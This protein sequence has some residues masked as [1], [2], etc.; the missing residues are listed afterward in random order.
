MT[1]KR[2]KIAVAMGDG[3]GPEIMDATLRILK[4]AGARLD[5]EEVTVGEKAYLAGETK[6]ISDADFAKLEAVDAFL[7]APLNTPQGKGYSSV[8]VAI[9]KHFDLFTNIRPSVSLEPVINSRSGAQGVDLVMIRENLEDLYAGIESRPSA[10]VTVGRKVITKSESERIIRTAFEYARVNG[11][12]KVTAIAK[13]NIQ[14]FTDGTNFH[15]V[16]DEVAQ[17][18]PDITPEFYIADIGLARLGPR[19]SDFDVVVTQNM[20]GDIGSDVVG[21]SLGS[22]GISGSANIGSDFAMFEAVH[23]T[24]PDIQGKDLANPTGLLMASVMMLN[25]LGQSDVAEKVHNAL[26][27]TLEAGYMTG[28]VYGGDYATHKVGTTDF[29]SAVIKRMGQTPNILKPVDYSAVKDGF[30][31]PAFKTTH[32]ADDFNA[33]GIDVGIATLDDAKTLAADLQSRCPY[34]LELT[35]IR[36]VRGDKVWPEESRAFGSDYL[37]ARFM[38]EDAAADQSQKMMDVANLTMALSDKNIREMTMLTTSADGRT[39]NFR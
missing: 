15:D 22:I 28:D 1:A 26:L 12:N 31:I 6:G 21:E 4:S 30:E 33:V 8:N 2:A 7:K 9:R 24:A 32:L 34:G 16:F 5:I 13:D 19:A 25:Y 39:L 27:S 20:Y 36:S 29:A 37:T 10:D 23:G 11:R 18:Y 14:K 38:F 35:E 17:D 3:I